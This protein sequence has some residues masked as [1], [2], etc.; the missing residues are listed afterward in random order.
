MMSDKA[1][2]KEMLKRTVGLK[3]VPAQSGVSYYLIAMALESSERV[4]KGMLTL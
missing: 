1:R 4:G 3:C 2:T